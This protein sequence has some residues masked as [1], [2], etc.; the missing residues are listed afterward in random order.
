GGVTD[1]RDALAFAA[2]GAGG[3]AVGSALLHDPTA[4]LR[5]LDELRTELA[6][7]GLAAFTDAVGL[8]HRRD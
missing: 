8:A 6:S 7:R 4:P 5:I 3:V 2:A 1:G